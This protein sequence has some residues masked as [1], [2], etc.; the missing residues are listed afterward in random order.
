[1]LQASELLF[2]DAWLFRAPR[3]MD[4]AELLAMLGQPECRGA[5]L[6]TA[7]WKSAW[8]CARELAGPLQVDPTTLLSAAAAAEGGEGGA[9][10]CQTLGG[11]GT[12]SGEIRGGLAEEGIS[13]AGCT[14]AMQ[15]L[16]EQIVLL[17]RCAE[18]D[19]SSLALLG[20]LVGCVANAHIAAQVL[21]GQRGHV[22][23]VL[24]G[25]ADDKIE[26][27]WS[28]EEADEF[29]VSPLH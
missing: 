13:W 9:D 1:M 25:W 23:V 6:D 28:D 18:V 5:E 22:S 8:Q 3:E 7:R 20:R 15:N 21:E 10:D 29:C 24:H 14:T 26:A 16:S 2:G 17:I 12:A 27:D 19:A 4:K 11:G